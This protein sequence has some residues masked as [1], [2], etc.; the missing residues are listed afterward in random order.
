MIRFPNVCMI[1]PVLALGACATNA[2]D[3][4]AS[5]PAAAADSAPVAGPDPHALKDPE[6][7][8]S[9][10]FA[11][12]GAAPLPVDK[13]FEELSEEQKSVY[14]SWYQNLGSNDDPPFPENGLLNLYQQTI[15]LHNKFAQSH[16]GRR[17]TVG[18]YFIVVPVDEH[19]VAHSI[20]IRKVGANG[21]HGN[22]E[23]DEG[24][25]NYLAAVFMREKYRPA[26]CGGAPCAMDFAV[27]L[28]LVPDSGY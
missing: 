8:G 15:G 23:P 3:P 27:S 2:G 17:G 14:R 1:L 21:I 5:P 9:E 10:V 25:A 20:A 7:G 19:G 6:Y 22:F 4:A 16:G 11:I 28:N 18:R 26:Q 24:I 13:R 12:V